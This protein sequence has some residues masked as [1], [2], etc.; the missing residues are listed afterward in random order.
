MSLWGRILRSRCISKC[1]RSLL[2]AVANL[3]NRCRPKTELASVLIDADGDIVMQ[4]L[5]DPT[6]TSKLVAIVEGERM[7]GFK[8]PFPEVSVV[9]SRSSAI[10]NIL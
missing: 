8:S 9:C 2:D 6:I 1:L 10:A 4:D 5:D 3:R 7:S